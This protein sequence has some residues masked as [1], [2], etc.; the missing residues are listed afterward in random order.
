MHLKASDL[1]LHENL[2]DLTHLSFL[3]IN[4]FGT[5]DYAS[6][7]F[8]TVLDQAQGCFA[9]ER[10]VVPTRPPPLWALLTGLDG[11][12]AARIARSTFVS[13]ALHLVAVKFYACSKP[14][15]QQPVRAIRT[16]HIAPPESATSCHYV[17][18]HARNFGLTDDAITAFMHAQLR[19]A[20]Q[21]DVNGLEAQ[22]ALLALYPERQPEVSIQADKAS[23]AMRRYL[24]RR[25]EAEACA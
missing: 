21:E 10:S 23:L 4:S 1:R 7:P 17:I 18:P 16:A 19:K 22:E 15:A 2:L 6:A 25:A 8:N 3:H 13:P 24:K 9:I 12:D 14:E 5:S 11:V 20:F